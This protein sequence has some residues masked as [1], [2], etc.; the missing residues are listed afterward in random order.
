MAS[1]SSLASGWSRAVATVGAA[2]GVMGA[3]AVARLQAAVSV[4]DEG[5][6]I[7][8]KEIELLSGRDLAA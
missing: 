4:T 1:A 5:F 7:D 8:G 2:V 3:A 6:A